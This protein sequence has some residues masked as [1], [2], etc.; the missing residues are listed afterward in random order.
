MHSWARVGAVLGAAVFAVT[1]SLPTAGASAVKAA[2]AEQAVAPLAVNYLQNRAT[3]R[4]LEDNG[5]PRTSVGPC[6]LPSMKWD[7]QSVGE[8]YVTIRNVNSG[9]CLDSNGSAV[10]LGGCNGGY[11]QKW[12]LH[13]DGVISHAVYGQSALDSNANGS[14]YLQYQNG[15]NYQ[16]WNRG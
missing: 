8:G 7:I 5:G 12:S 3:G 14:V 15:G 13:N 11:Y 4:C 10:Y 9:R 2:D 1:V 16:K 6:A